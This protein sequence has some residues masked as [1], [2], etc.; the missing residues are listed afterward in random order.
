LKRIEGTRNARV[1]LTERI[2]NKRTDFYSIHSPVTILTDVIVK[3]TGS[4][5]KIVNLPRQLHNSN[6][7]QSSRKC[8]A[9][10]EILLVSNE[11]NRKS[12]LKRQL[13]GLDFFKTACAGLK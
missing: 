1:R 3:I 11:T 8:I 2:G 7:S 4:F 10:K 13:T 5:F 9:S 6:R 12:S